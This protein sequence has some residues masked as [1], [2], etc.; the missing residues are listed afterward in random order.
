MA[1]MVQGHPA[2]VGD[3]CWAGV[4]SRVS[5]HGDAPDPSLCSAWAAS[6][7]CG[8]PCASYIARS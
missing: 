7:R 2:L 8:G 1:Q 4:A 5:R 3:R 6:V